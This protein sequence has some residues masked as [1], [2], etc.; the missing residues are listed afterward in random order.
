MR[1]RYLALGAVF[2]GLLGLAV[3]LPGWLARLEAA[4]FTELVV[5]GRL[6]HVDPAAVRDAARPYL[7][8]GF[9]AVDMEALRRRI[10]SLPWVARA[11]L[12]REWP[13]RLHVSLIEEVPVATWHGRGLLN[14]YGEVFLEETAGYEGRLPDLAG[15]DGTQSVLL[16]AHAD[17]QRLLADRGVELARI[18]LSE[19]RA[20]RLYLAGGTEVR[21]GSEKVEARLRRFA[22]VALPALRES[23]ERIEYVDM[24]YTNGF[25]VRAQQTTPG[26]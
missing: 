4:R 14:A 23:L 12:R 10:E 20:W 2:L 6:S 17:M 26:V 9:M 24:R 8:A 21:L 5:R 16:A 18:A 3:Q 22:R 13:G 25:A 15:P 1:L 19:R 11:R 7:D